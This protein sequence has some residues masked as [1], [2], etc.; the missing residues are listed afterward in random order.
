MKPGWKTTEFWLGAVIPQLLGLAVMTGVISSEQQ[1]VV[2][3]G[4]E[5]LAESG[6]QVYGVYLSMA[7][8]FGYAVSRGIAKMKGE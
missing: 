8:A 3:D 5:V 1:K 4:A 7:S 2:Q 6:T